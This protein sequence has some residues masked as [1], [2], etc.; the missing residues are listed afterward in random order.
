MGRY[1]FTVK[2]VSD[3]SDIWEYTASNW[4]EDQADKY[5]KMLVDGCER[6]SKDTDLGKKY[7]EV[8][9]TIFGFRTGQHIIFYRVLQTGDIEIIRI[10]HARMDLKSRME[11]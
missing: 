11:E 4:S 10:L 6:L 8:A 7:P 3:L 2:A 5:Y 1:Q 9:S